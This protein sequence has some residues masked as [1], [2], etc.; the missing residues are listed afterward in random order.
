MCKSFKKVKYAKTSI[1]GS[2]IPLDSI[3]EVLLFVDNPETPKYLVDFGIHGKAIV[4]ASYL[5]EIE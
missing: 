5:K 1:H 4:P 2:S 3:G